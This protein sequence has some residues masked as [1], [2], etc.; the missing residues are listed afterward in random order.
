M[1]IV[2]LVRGIPVWQGNVAFCTHIKRFG[3]PSDEKDVGS[4]KDFRK[5]LEK[6]TNCFKFLVG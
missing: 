1:D 2:S 5:S 3:S 6:R 4:E